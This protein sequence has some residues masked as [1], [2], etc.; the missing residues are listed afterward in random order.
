MKRWRLW[1]QVVKE[2]GLVIGVTILFLV[3]VGQG[4]HGSA[5]GV[6]NLVVEN[7]ETREEIDSGWEKSQEVNTNAE[8]ENKEERTREPAS[9][10]TEM[11]DNETLASRRLGAKWGRIRLDNYQEWLM[12]TPVYI[13]NSQVWANSPPT[14]F[15]AGIRTLPVRHW[16][17]FFQP[18]NWGFFFLPLDQAFS[19]LWWWPIWAVFVGGWFWARTFFR[20]RN[21]LFANGLALSLACLPVIHWSANLAPATYLVWT[22]VFLIAIKKLFEADFWAK[23][24]GWLSLIIYAGLALVLGGNSNSQSIIFAS[25]IIIISVAIYFEQRKKCWRY[26][27]Y[28]LVA[29]AVWLSLGQL[30]H[31]DFAINLPLQTTDLVNL[32]D[33]KASLNNYWLSSFVGLFQQATAIT[34]NFYTMPQN[35]AWGLM[36][37]LPFLV[38]MGVNYFFKLKTK[39]FVANSNWLIIALVGVIIVGNIWLYFGWPDLFYTTAY[40]ASTLKPASLY[41]VLA[42]TGYWL[43]AYYVSDCSLFGPLAQKKDNQI[44]SRFRSYFISLVVFW[45]LLLLVMVYSLQ[46]DYPEFFASY[47]Y[48]IFLIPL[49]LIGIELLLIFRQSWAFLLLGIASFF[50]VWLVNP[51]SANILADFQRPN[52]VASLNQLGKQKTFLLVNT[53]RLIDYSLANLLMANG[54]DILNFTQ[55]QSNPDFYRE[56][57]PTQSFVGLYSRPHN[58][59]Y[60]WQ[61]D[62]NSEVIMADGGNDTLLISF[63]PCQNDYFRQRVDYFLTWQ[64]ESND[65]ECLIEITTYPTGQDLNL[66]ILG[67]R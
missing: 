29:L 19:W 50:S 58:A 32:T 23:E 5:S 26:V 7:S 15:A 8:K 51:I 56:L 45:N 4:W 61:N 66:R 49:G 11:V 13:T 47:F 43:V 37:T 22:L 17:I 35:S 14:E 62:L 67:W 6:Y 55:T 48:L 33:Q 28:L 59:I 39:K 12:T 21:S 36:I 40:L 44:N 65:P 27:L 25:F 3:A 63:N 52:L 9:G 34:T 30:Y 46:L 18:Q 24:T 60:V 1:W 41:P 16:R 57:D 20:S 31:H 54:I 53:Y 42:L 2:Y 10:E 38:I 64:D